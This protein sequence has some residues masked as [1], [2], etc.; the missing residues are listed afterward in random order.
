MVILSASVF[1]T[2]FCFVSQNNDPDIKDKNGDKTRQKENDYIQLGS[3]RH[4]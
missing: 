1:F 3:K 2:Y 4:Q